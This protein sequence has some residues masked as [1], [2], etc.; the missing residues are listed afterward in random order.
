[1]TRYLSGELND[2]EAEQFERDWAHNPAWTKELELDA[3]LQGGLGELRRRGQ[4]E[5][6]MRGPW[7]A[8]SLRIL[9]LA[10]TVAGLG[11]AIGVW[12]SGPPAGLALLA[13]TPTLRVG[14]SVAV[15]RL[16]GAEKFAGVVE[17]PRDPYSIELRVLPD[18]AGTTATDIYSMSLD[19]IAAITTAPRFSV[20][21]LRIGA[22][23]FVRVYVDSEKIAPGQYRLSLRHA[24]AQDTDDFLILF[25][26]STASP[27]A[28]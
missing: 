2:V 22:D 4:L 14:N 11:F 25:S 10:A 9:A 3:R 17:L 5:S 28:D 12:Q 7:W 15:M 16:R 8:K 21:N 19:P 1:M 6:V 27:H 18:V 24:G 23:G 20:D 26:G 13:S